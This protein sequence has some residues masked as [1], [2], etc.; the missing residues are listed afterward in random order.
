L[1]RALDSI[2]S[3]QEDRA[4]TS[5]RNSGVQAAGRFPLICL[6]R[7]TTSRKAL[8]N[9][10]PKS[11][12]GRS[13]RKAMKVLSRDTL[14]FQS[15]TTSFSYFGP[16][17]SNPWESG[18]VKGGIKS[19]QRLDGAR[20]CG[21]GWPQRGQVGG[22]LSLRDAVSTRRSSRISRARHRTEIVKYG[23]GPT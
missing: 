9:T 16:G 13:N 17:G 2:W 18:Q 5:T 12:R 19:Y 15:K 23:N 8:A 21:T 22:N 3:E 7:G 6:W 4:K 10:D 1:R 11:L 14:S 20:N